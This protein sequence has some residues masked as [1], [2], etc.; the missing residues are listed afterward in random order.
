MIDLSFQGNSQIGTLV[1]IRV[2]V[3]AVNTDKM[4]SSPLQIMRQVMQHISKTKGFDRVMNKVQVVSAEPGKC[5]FEMKVAEEHLNLPGDSSRRLNGDLVD[6]LTTYALLSMEGG[7]PGVSVDLHVSYLK[8]A[9]PGET[10]TIAA[11]VLKMGRTLAYTTA[12][13]KNEQGDVIAQ[14]LHTKHV[15]N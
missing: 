14:G 9:K 13:I 6:G 8:A 12:Q 1:H 11:E 15:G 3:D 5:V 2:R 10:I 4:A 7:K